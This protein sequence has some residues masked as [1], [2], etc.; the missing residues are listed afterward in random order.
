MLPDCLKLQQVASDQ[1]AATLRVKRGALLQSVP[2]GSAAAKAG[3]QATRRGL[4]GVI[5]GEETLL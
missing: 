5:I 3:L 2:A 4:T 1:V